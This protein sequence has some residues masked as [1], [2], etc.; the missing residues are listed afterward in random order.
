MVTQ[1]AL[2]MTLKQHV[3]SNSR[4]KVYLLI[5]INIAIGIG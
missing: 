2:R 4:A 3:V 5:L 1:F